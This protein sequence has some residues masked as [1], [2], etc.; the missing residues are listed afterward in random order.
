MP[1]SKSCSDL[2][3]VYTPKIRSISSS[4]SGRRH[5]RLPSSVTNCRAQ[6]SS[7]SAVRALRKRIPLL[8]A[9][10]AVTL[11][12]ALAHYAQSGGAHLPWVQGVGGVVFCLLYDKTQS[13]WSPY[14]V[15]ALGNLALFS[16]PWFR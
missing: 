12:F 8:P 9:L 15:H 3:Q 6:A 13:L 2:P 5:A 1:V 10:A 7:P 16:L 11:I 14:L 4:T